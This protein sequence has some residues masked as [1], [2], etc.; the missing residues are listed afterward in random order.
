[1]TI[2]RAALLIAAI[3][4]GSCS[5]TNDSSADPVTIIQR[6]AEFVSALTHAHQWVRDDQGF[7]PAGSLATIAA[8]RLR[9]KL[10][11]DASSSLELSSRT[12]DFTVRLTPTGL[13]PVEGLLLTNAVLYR[14]AEPRTDVLWIA[15][16]ASVE[17][18]R[19]VHEVRSQIVVSYDLELPAGASAEVEDDGS[20]GM[21]DSAHVLRLKSAPPFALDANGLKRSMSVELGARHVEFRLDA[22][23]MTP[24]IVVDP[25][26]TATGNMA[27]LHRNNFT[28]TVLASG[29]VLLAGG[30]ITSAAEIFDPVAKTWT[31]TTSLPAG[32]ESHQ[33]ALLPSGK[34]LLCGGISGPVVGTCLTFDPVT[35]KWTLVPGMSTPRFAFHFVKLSSGQILAAGGATVAGVSSP[36]RTSSAEIFDPITETWT[37]ASSLA[38]ARYNGAAFLLASGK[39]AVVGGTGDTPTI[40][41][42]ELFDPSTKAWK[43][44]ASLLAPRNVVT[45]GVLRD[46]RVLVLGGPSDSSCEMYDPTADK[47]T[48]APSPPVLAWYPAMSLPGG[49]IAGSVSGTD[50]YLYDVATDAWIKGPSLKGF[51]AQPTLTALGGGML[52]AVG[53]NSDSATAIYSSN[54]DGTACAKGV[55]CASGYCTAGLCGTTTDAGTDAVATDTAVADSSAADTKGETPPGTKSDGAACGGS[56]ECSSNNCVDGVC[57][58]VE[59]AGQCQACDIPGRVGTCAVV[60]GAPHGPRVKCGDDSTCAGRCDGVDT[61][62]CL[63]P[64]VGLSCTPVCADDGVSVRACDGKGS[65]VGQYTTPCSPYTCDGTTCRTACTKN[66]DC[67]P[68][69]ACSDGQCLPLSTDQGLESSGCGCGVSAQGQTGVL[70][71]LVLIG[72]FVKRRRYATRL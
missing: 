20:V 68:A 36:P 62:K 43:A 37:A 54:A 38:T 48:A 10:P 46:G 15:T 57:C 55:E 25:T 70:V 8:D 49:L 60:S 69:S 44:G 66:A 63:Y 32:R 21:F 27:V 41:S 67:A 33:A 2:L 28:V 51:G 53:T 64:A 17:E 23:D 47:W 26:W 59:C 4:V 1:M 72:A 45:G 7:V 34:V 18:V 56:S 35:S 61:Q 30:E 19:V 29:K 52:L 58:N 11:R 24:P 12:S 6:H 3:G 5:R 71:A 9:V 13:T 14:N 31:T 16:E 42:V 65:C 40:S 39:V 50:M 22:R